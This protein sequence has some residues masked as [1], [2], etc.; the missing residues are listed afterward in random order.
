MGA[1]IVYAL[2]AT[3]AANTDPLLSNIPPA[4]GG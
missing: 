3:Q 1:E 2:V 4:M